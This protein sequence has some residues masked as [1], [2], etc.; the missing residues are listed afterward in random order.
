MLR[1]TESIDTASEGDAGRLRPL[2]TWIEHNLA[3]MGDAFMKMT[4]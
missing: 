2:A 3:S 4:R 1:S